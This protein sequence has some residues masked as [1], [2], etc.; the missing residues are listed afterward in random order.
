MR[1]VLLA[2][3]LG[4]RLRPLT[5]RIPKCLVLIKG[6]PLLDI[7]CESLLSSGV[8]KIL[9]NLHYMREVVEE[10]IQ[11]SSYK[12]QVQTVFEPVLLGTAGTLV[13]NKEF[14]KGDDGILVHA[15]NYSEVDVY[16]LIKMHTQRPPSCLMTMLAFRTTTPQTCG[17]LE[18]DNENILQQMFEKSAEDHGNLAN[19]AMY[20]LSPELVS[21]LKNEADFSNQVIPRFIQRI[22]VVETNK[23]YI[24]IGTPETYRLAQEIANV[25]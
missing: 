13:A 23:I 14:F 20:V 7:W 12:K 15:D 16:E 22:F 3:G 24:D 19:G 21:S 10:H 2:A 5:D 17:I 25:R 4:T 11:S 6:K 8:E 9:I 1:A 18:V